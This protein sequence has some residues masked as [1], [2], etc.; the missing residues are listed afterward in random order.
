MLA[1]ATLLLLI[2]LP[3]VNCRRRNA[4]RIEELDEDLSAKDY[5][6]RKRD[7]GMVKAMNAY[8]SDLR[9]I[10]RNTEKDSCSSV[11]EIWMQALNKSCL[12]NETRNKR[13]ICQE[14]MGL[15]NCY[16]TRSGNCDECVTLN[17]DR[18]AL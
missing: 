16:C 2:A 12:C 8:S 5:D 11:F 18:L 10:K 13:V 17:E 1:A 6:H 14:T 4:L 7:N 3:M 15:K 9:T